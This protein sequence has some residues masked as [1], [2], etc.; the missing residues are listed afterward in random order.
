MIEI[1]K[2]CKRPMTPTT[3]LDN[4]VDELL[5]SPLTLK[6]KKTNKKEVSE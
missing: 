2:T 6:Q 4:F 1:K 3:P 5:R